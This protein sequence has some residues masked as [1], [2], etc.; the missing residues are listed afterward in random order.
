[1]SNPQVIMF[2]RHSGDAVTVGMYIHSE[3]QLA[4]QVKAMLEHARPRWG[5]HGY[6][7]R[8]A[9]AFVLNQSPW[10]V[11]GQ[12]GTGIMALSPKEV[13]EGWHSSCGWFPEIIWNERM[14]IVRHVKQDRNGPMLQHVEASRQTFTFDE[15]L[16]LVDENT[17]DEEVIGFRS[18]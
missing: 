5:D 15:W 13:V 9:I 2:S 14:V 12:L 6:D 7:T 3:Y 11:L 4:Q 16:K 1:M 18:E 17:N 10:G 8:M